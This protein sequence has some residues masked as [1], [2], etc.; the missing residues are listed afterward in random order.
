[1]VSSLGPGV[2][3]GLRILK[4]QVEGDPAQGQGAQGMLRTVR[5][6]PVKQGEF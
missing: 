2:K 1:M 6:V 3:R 4:R 5:A